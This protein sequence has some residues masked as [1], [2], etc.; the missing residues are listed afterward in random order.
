MKSTES[1]VSKTDS[2]RNPNQI[3]ELPVEDYLMLNNSDQ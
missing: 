3:K 2:E 1:M